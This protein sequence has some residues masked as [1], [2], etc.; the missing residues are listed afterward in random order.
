[1]EEST[2][3][4]VVDEFTDKNGLV[5]KISVEDKDGNVIAKYTDSFSASDVAGYA[6]L[7]DEHILQMAINDY[8]DKEQE[9]E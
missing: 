7:L 8:N 2:I 4:K 1:M 3:E 5:Y 9:D 6:G